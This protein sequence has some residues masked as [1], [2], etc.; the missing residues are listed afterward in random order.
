MEISPGGL[1]QTLRYYLYTRRIGV[2]SFPRYLSPPPVRD[3][4]I[5]KYCRSHIRRLLFEIHAFRILNCHSR[6]IGPRAARFAWNVISHVSLPPPT[7]SNFI[8]RFTAA[9]SF[10]VYCSVFFLPVFTNV[11]Y[12]NSGNWFRHRV[13][14]LIT[15][16]I[17]GTFSRKTTELAK[18]YFFNI[19]LNFFLLS[20]F[21]HVQHSFKISWGE[22]IY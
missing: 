22:T 17:N 19:E 11:R 13:N 10:I 21:I 4:F 1:H 20:N 6:F 2:R 18:W 8:I 15:C 16:N 5:G 3:F 12:A 14:D 7:S 9:A